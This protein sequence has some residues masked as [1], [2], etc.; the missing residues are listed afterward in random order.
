MMESVRSASGGPLKTPPM[1]PARNSTFLDSS[2]LLV[3]TRFERLIIFYLDAVGLR[4]GF[5]FWLGRLGGAELGCDC[6]PIYLGSPSA[7]VATLRMLK[8]PRRRTL[9]LVCPSAKDATVRDVGARIRSTVA[10]NIAAQRGILVLQPNRAKPAAD[11]W[12]KTLMKSP[13][14]TLGRFAASPC[15]TAGPNGGRVEYEIRRVP[16]YGARIEAGDKGRCHEQL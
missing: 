8:K 13:L 9:I 16:R 2:E 5:Q 1:K 12:I 4:H 6:V 7:P 14:F 10:R 15:A 11:Q 3:A